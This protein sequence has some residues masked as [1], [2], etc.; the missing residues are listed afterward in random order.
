MKCLICNGELEELVA[1]LKGNISAYPSGGVYDFSLCICKSCSL[2]QKYITKEYES[3]LDDVYKNH[4][5]FFSN[6]QNTLKGGEEERGRLEIESVANKD[7]FSWLDYGCGG[8]HF[9]RLLNKIRPNFKIYGYDVA[10][11]NVE[12]FK[13]CKIERLFFGGEKIDKKFDYI[14]LNMV[15][16]HLFNPLEVLKSLVSN[17][18]ENG[19]MLIRIPNFRFLPTD[20]YI[21]EHTMHFQKSTIDFLLNKV[22]LKFEKFISGIPNIEYA[23]VASKDSNLCGGGGAK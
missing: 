1:N 14:S 18:K 19:K 23:L 21:Y 3:L 11:V 13:D 2:V 10:D 17:L 20:L 12:K 4:Y 7:G 22:G 6:E 16:E 8:G 5:T 9:I 15:L